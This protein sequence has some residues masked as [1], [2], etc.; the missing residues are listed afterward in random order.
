MDNNINALIKSVNVEKARNIVGAYLYDSHFQGMT[1]DEILNYEG[2]I[3]FEKIE[4]VGIS[5]VTGDTVKGI[6]FCKKVKELNITMTTP[7][8]VNF[9]SD[10]SSFYQ[11]EKFTIS[12]SSTALQVAVGQLNVSN[13]KYLRLNNTRGVGADL[14]N[15]SSNIEYVHIALIN[16]G[17]YIIT[18]LNFTNKVKLKYVFLTG[19]YITTTDITKYDNLRTCIALENFS[20]FPGQSGVAQTIVEKVLLELLTQKQAGGAIKTISVG[21]TCNTNATSYKNSLI[22]L[23]V[24]VTTS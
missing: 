18:P 9:I 20:L 16:S 8:A 23:G 6:N 2:I 19:S 10:V 3:S 24:S 12:H 13:L 21:G 4:N 11:I 1:I 15:I 14:A 5:T 7:N 22:A 17:N